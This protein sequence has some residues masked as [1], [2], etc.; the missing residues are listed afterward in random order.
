LAARDLPDSV[1]LSTEAYLGAAEFYRNRQDSSHAAFRRIVLEDP[2]YRLDPLAFP[3][4]VTAQFDSVR[5]ATPAVSVEVPHRVTVEPGRGGLT[6][7]VYPSGPHVVRVRVETSAGDVVRTLRDG[8]ASGDFSVTWDGAAHDG[9]ALASGLYVLSFAS[10]GRDRTV[11]RVVDVPVRLE[12]VTVNAQ[13]LPARPAMLPE[14]ASAGPALLR[15]GLGAGAGA[16][17]WIVIPAFT[18]DDAPRIA[19]SLA[20]TTA[21]IVGFFEARPGKAIPENAAAN[22][23][24]LAAWEAEVQRMT[25]ADAR[26]RPGPR[27]ILETARPSV[28]R[29]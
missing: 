21:G 29:Q 25:E 14:T 23:A 24:A 6:A 10:I 8:R 28:R 12:R 16:L 17:A 18:D 4:E 20:F 1:T 22:R 15:L 9:G 27:L 13:A 19:F 26:R 11:R 7:L 2:R 3:P 5:F